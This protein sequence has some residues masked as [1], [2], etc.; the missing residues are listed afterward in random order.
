MSALKDTQASF[1]VQEV[2]LIA[3]VLLELG[4]RDG[5]VSGFSNRRG[6]IR[7]RR[8]VQV[9]ALRVWQVP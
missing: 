1:D 8:S 2:E 7:C 3:Q 4:F 5:T 9:S 6:G